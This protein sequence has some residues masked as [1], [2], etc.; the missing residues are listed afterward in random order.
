MRWELDYYG[1]KTD[2]QS[3]IPKPS[4]CELVICIFWKRLG[5]E[6]PDKYARPDGT[7]PTGTEY[8]FEEALQRRAASPDKLPD[9]L[10]YRKTAEVTFS[11]ATLDFERAQYDRFMAFWQRWF[12]NEKGHFL[13]GFQTFAT[14]DE[15]E[16][17]FERNLRGM[18]ARSR[19]RNH[20]DQGL[21]L[22]R[23]RAVQR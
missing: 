12:R 21:A 17:V 6:L 3:Q 11:A 8:E 1:A 9:V 14:P 23:A 19:D 7:M 15:F 20:L 22:S 2:F 18:A 13:A 5:S 4:E 10:V 16:A